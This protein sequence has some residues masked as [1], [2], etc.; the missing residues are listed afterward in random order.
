MQIA[1]MICGNY[2][3]ETSFFVYRSSSRLTEFFR[4]CDTEYAH[5]NSTRNYW[6]A[7]VLRSILTEPQPGPN[8]P[9]DTF[10][11]VIEMPPGRLIS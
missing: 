2:P 3:T 11:R 8:T 4:D 6:V 1:D 7:E 9:P 5:D 10:A